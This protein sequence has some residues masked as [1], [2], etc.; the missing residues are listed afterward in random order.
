MYVYFTKQKCNMH[1]RMIAIFFNIKAY[2]CFPFVINYLSHSTDIL[3]DH[4]NK[5]YKYSTDF[6]RLKGFLPT[7]PS[8]NIVYNKIYIQMYFI[9]SLPSNSA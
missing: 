8:N 4:N 5:L 6:E 3:L 2:D 7:T 9:I 1:E